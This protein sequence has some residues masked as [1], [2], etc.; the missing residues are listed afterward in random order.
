MTVS[1]SQIKRSMSTFW[2]YDSPSSFP[3]S[4]GIA[5]FIKKGASPLKFTSNIP[6]TKPTPALISNQS[7]KR[8]R[9]ASNTLTTNQS[10]KERQEQ[11][12]NDPT[13][14]QKR[15]DWKKAMLK[16]GIN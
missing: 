2:K 7:N 5:D 14:E 3:F 8:K 15:T 9:E 10:K 6:E 4:T 12:N 1:N 13:L 11:S 16:Y